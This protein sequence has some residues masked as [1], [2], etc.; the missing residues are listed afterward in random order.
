MT[1][2]SKTPE[3]FNQFTDKAVDAMTLWADANQR[4]ARELVELSVGAA[5]ESVRLYAEIQQ[6]AI[7]AMRETQATALRWQSAWQEAPKDPVRWYQK[8]LVESVDT[9]QKAF[10]FVEGTSQAVTR[11]AERLQASAEQ[12]GKSIQETFTSLVGKTKDL[13]S[14][15]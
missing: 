1:E 7:E 2:A 6:G 11:S 15:N 8:T 14:Q 9:A 3:P 12:A 5:K 13:Y 4:V 10:R